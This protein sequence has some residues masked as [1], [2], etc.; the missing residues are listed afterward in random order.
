MVAFRILGS[1]ILCVQM[2][3]GAIGVWIAMILDWICRLTCFILR[4]R[5]TKWE[6]KAQIRRA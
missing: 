6:M 4:Y 3:W 5:G 2:E 1:W